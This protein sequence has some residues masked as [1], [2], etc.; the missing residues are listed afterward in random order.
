MKYSFSIH[1]LYILDEGGVCLYYRHFTNQFK[2]LDLDLI[3]PFFSAI[4]SFT[5][6][7]L[8][9]KLEFL[10][11]SDLRFAFKKEKGFIFVLLADSG[12][13]YLYINS[14]LEK[15]IPVFFRNFPKIINNFDGELL[16]NPDFDN[17]VDFLLYGQDEIAKIQNHESYDKILSFFSD[18]ISQNEIIGAAVITTKGTIIY[19]SLTNDVLVR[20]MKE[21]EIRYITGTFDI[22][23]L[24]Y[25]LANGQK[26]CE[27]TVSYAN[28]INLIV[29]IQFSSSIQFG[30]VDFQAENIINKF[31]SFI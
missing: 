17:V 13:N 9:K 21:L 3:T 24:F 26:I 28:F 15:V 1:S 7:T 16:E 5:T 2:H 12:E 22:P 19:S 25:T 31:K 11:L 27:R 6:S 30:M 10:E 18:L 4:L 14:R 20:A 8:S 23:Q 29:I